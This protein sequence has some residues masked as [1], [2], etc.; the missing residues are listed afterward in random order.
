M[1]RLFGRRYTRKVFAGTLLVAVI[2]VVSG[3][4]LAGA[5]TRHNDVVTLTTVSTAT[6]AASGTTLTTPST[7]N[8]PV[9]AAQADAVAVKSQG[10][11]NVVLE[12]ALANLTDTG[13]PGMTNRLAWVV[14]VMPYGGF[15]WSHGG[16]GT[17]PPQRATYMLVFVDANTG[18]YLYGA[19]GGSVAS[20]SSSSRRSGAPSTAKD[21]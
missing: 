16:V 1:Y 6:L 2:G 5:H 19:S 12:H 21:R 13:V 15:T 3:V 10:G 18:D 7:S 20:S 11:G 14:S 4:S 17:G 9:T 8:P